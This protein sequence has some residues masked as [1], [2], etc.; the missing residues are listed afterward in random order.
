MS[1][2]SI[3]AL[4]RTKNLPTQTC[5]QYEEI[6][7]GGPDSLRFLHMLTAE[8]KQHLNQVINEWLDVWFTQQLEMQKLSARLCGASLKEATYEYNHKNINNYVRDFVR[9]KGKLPDAKTIATDLKINRA[10]VTKH[11]A[12]SKNATSKLYDDY[13]IIAHDVVGTIAGVALRNDDVKAAKA[14]MDIMFKLK[15]NQPVPTQ[16]QLGDLVITQQMLDTL[17]AAQKDSIKELLKSEDDIEEAEVQVEE[18]VKDETPMPEEKPV[19]NLTHSIQLP[20]VNKTEKLEMDMPV[21]EGKW[22]KGV[23]YITTKQ[24]T[25]SK[26]ED[27]KEKIPEEKKP[28]NS[29]FRNRHG[30][31]TLFD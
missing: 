20:E 2:L 10:T 12:D 15:K 24:P 28:D 21:Q 18:E 8:E 3:E 6:I 25:V 17:T 16:V 30:G 14:Y 26:V 7:K 23:L 4:L 5:I 9:R 11:L 31:P 29:I 1:A 13:Q 22:V 19:D 27:V